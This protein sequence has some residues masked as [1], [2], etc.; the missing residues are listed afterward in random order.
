MRMSSQE[1]WEYL[2]WA[3]A[4]HLTEVFPDEILSDSETLEYEMHDAR[5]KWIE[6]HVTERNEYQHSD[7]IFDE[8][9]ILAVSA[10][11]LVKEKINGSTA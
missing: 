4:H 11:E 10:F 3:S 9:H 6:D 2:K 1:W 8:I 5:I 7:D